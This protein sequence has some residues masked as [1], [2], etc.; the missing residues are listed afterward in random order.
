MLQPG[1]SYEAGTGYRYGFNK[2]EKS[3]E[4][5]ENSTTAMFWEY[6]SRTGRRWNVDLKPNVGIS[7]YST[8]ANNPIFYS[9]PL[10]DTTVTGAG[11]THSVNIDEKLNSLE[12]YNSKTNYFVAGTQTPVPIQPGQLRSF[13]N[14]LGK[15]S[16][17]WTTNA[18]GTANFAG[19]KND[20]GQDLDAA[21]KEFNEITSSWKYKLWSFGNWIGREHDKDPVGFNLKITTSLL[22]MSAMQAVEPV[23]Y[24][25]GYNPSVTLSEGGED[26]GFAYRAI[27]PAFV[28][29]TMQNGFYMSGAPGRLGND[30]IYVNSTIEGA[31][32]EFQFHNPGMNPAIFEVRYPLSKPLLVNPPAG[33]FSQPLPFTQGANILSAPS[34]RAPGTINLLIRAG[35]EVG[36]KIQ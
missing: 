2:Q 8:F 32:K 35:V 26:F 11:G 21:V 18:N 17:T 15:F 30:G 33:Y 12:Y 34:V 31:I 14:A 6:D 3:P 7:T 5:F 24:P 4:V 23:G 20:K 22:T 25:L 28:K 19:Y 29:S 13:S 10:G 27:N 1:R 9:D 16:A 36:K